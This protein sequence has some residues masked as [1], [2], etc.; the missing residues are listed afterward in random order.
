MK[1]HFRA[2]RA[3]RV[4]GVCSSARLAKWMSFDSVRD[5][6]SENKV[7]CRE[8]RL[9]GKSVLLFQSTRGWHSQHPESP[10]HSSDLKGTPIHI[11]HTHKH[12]NE[13]K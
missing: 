13:S 11:L 6:I 10:V 8:K 3:K 7:E 12:I 2:H 5:L 1:F 9:S 4:P